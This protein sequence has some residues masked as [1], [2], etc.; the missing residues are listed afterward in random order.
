MPAALDRKRIDLRHQ[1][2]HVQRLAEAEV[3]LRHLDRLELALAC[4]LDDVGAGFQVR[5]RRQLAAEL[6]A[7]KTLDYPTASVAVQ[8]LS[9]LASRG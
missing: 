3:H 5:Q 1:P 9:Q 7:Q 4:D 2:R 6:A 8:R